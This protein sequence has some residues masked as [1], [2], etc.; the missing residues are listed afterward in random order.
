VP[1]TEAVLIEVRGAAVAFLS[2]AVRLGRLSTMRVQAA[3]RR[4]D[5]VLVQAASAASG[6]TGDDIRSVAPELEIHS[7]AHLRSETRLFAT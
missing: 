6:L 7:L 2:A 4:L 1:R 5:P 3:L